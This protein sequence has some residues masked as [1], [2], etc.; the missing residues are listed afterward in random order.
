VRLDATDPAAA[1]AFANAILGNAIHDNAGLGIELG[2][3]VEGVGDG[4]TLNDAGDADDGPNR[5]QNFPMLAALTA[6]SLGGSLT[7]APS[8]TFRVEVFA[9]AA[10]DS[11][12]FGEGAVP[13]TAFDMTT[14]PGGVAVFSVPLAALPAGATVL[15]ATATDAL[16]NTSEFG[17]A[18]MVGGPPPPPLLGGIT[19]L[20]GG[21]FQ[22]QFAA[23]PGA[24]YTVEASTNLL[25][26][27]PLFTTN[28]PGPLLVL[29]DG[30]V[31]EFPARYFRVRSP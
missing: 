15:T 27:L 11:S 2:G 17:P 28:A 3:A 8:A 31:S 9:S 1:F 25:D 26:W 22:F 10:G 5:L 7:S 6:G 21:Q 29:P 30:N 14:D 23:Q 20:P 4:S 12:G 13:V 18:L 19:I 24:S 16:G